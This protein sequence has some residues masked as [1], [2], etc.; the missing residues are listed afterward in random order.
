MMMT[1]NLT[2]F[3]AAEQQP[4]EHIRNYPKMTLT[5]DDLASELNISRNTAYALAVRKDFPSFRIGR[6]LLVNRAMLQV[7]MDQ[8]CH[9]QAKAG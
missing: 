6:R 9:P 5:V 8:N 2:M 7:W 4:A 3:G 1:M